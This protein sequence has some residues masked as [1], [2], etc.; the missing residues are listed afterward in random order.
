MIG[1]GFAPGQAAPPTGSATSGNGGST[2]VGASVGTGSSSG[3]GLTSGAGGDVGIGTGGNCGQASVPIKATPPDVLIVQDKSG[4]MSEDDSGHNNG[5]ANSKWTQIAAALKQVVMANDTQINW[6][7]K[8]FSSNGACD[9]TGAPAVAVASGNYGAISTAIDGATPG[10]NTP[11]RDAVTTGAMYL[12]GVADSNNKYI[13]LATDG[14]PN[15]PTG[16]ANM[17]KPSTMCGMTDNPSEDQAATQA[18]SDALNNY[19]IKTFVIGV[20]DVATAQN[21]LNN[22]AM[23]G[24]LPQ[25][26]AA[27][28]YY[29]ATDSMALENALNA[30]IGAVFSCTVSLSTAPS[31]FTNVAVSA[32]DTTTGKPVEIM[33]DPTNGWSYDANKQ[34]ILLKGTACDNLKNGIYKDLNFIYACDGTKICIDRNSDGSCAD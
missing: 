23:A 28:S 29:A 5:A 34:N 33:P 7:L 8:F 32:T 20:G 9:A 13:L 24:G 27:T 21:T 25:Q 22:F 15:C 14:L 2:G 17:S 12:A 11:T 4:S 30:L 1:C 10:G 16:C 19:G 6:G 26:G 18:I 3:V 31:G